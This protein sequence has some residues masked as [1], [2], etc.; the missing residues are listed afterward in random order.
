MPGAS[1]FRSSEQA[2]LAGP[3]TFYTGTGKL[4]A[5]GKVSLTGKRKRGGF[6]ALIV[7]LLIGI[8]GGAFLPT[9][10]IPALL[11]ALARLSNIC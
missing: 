7:T 1:Y 2:A 11:S 6:A 10:S 9:L 8:G 5:T 4:P 3:R